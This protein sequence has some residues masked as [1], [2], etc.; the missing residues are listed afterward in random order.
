VD[1][2]TSEGTLEISD[3]RSTECSEEVPID[4]TLSLD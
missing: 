4:P 2:Y 1:T 3:S